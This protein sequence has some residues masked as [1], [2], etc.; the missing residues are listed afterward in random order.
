MYALHD[1]LCCLAHLAAACK[2]C[3]SALDSYFSIV[4]ECDSQM[5]SPSGLVEVVELR[6]GHLVGSSHLFDIFPYDFYALWLDDVTMVYSAEVHMGARDRFVQT[7]VLHSCV[8]DACRFS[9]IG[10]SSNF[11]RA[12]EVLRMQRGGEGPVREVLVFMSGDNPFI[13][14]K[15]FFLDVADALAAQEPIDTRALPHIDLRGAVLNIHASRTAATHRY[16][17][18]NCRPFLND[19]YLAFEGLSH[20]DS[21]AREIPDVSSAIDL[22]VFDL[23]TL[24]PCYS[25][26]GHHAFT[27]KNCLFF[28]YIDCL[29]FESDDGVVGLGRLLLCCMHGHLLC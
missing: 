13:T 28:L 2:I 18:V 27:L 10:S 9:L 22:L 6:N 15:L 3:W 16:L 7:L 23:H 21:F 5:G 29:A 12:P 26:R 8:R 1:M 11:A 25:F 17:M 24:T 19:D 4:M 14:Y 20:A